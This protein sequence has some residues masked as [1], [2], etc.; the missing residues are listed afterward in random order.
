MTEF[1]ATSV[2][3]HRPEYVAQYPIW[4][5]VRDAACGEEAIK[6]KSTQYLPKLGGHTADADGAALYA[7]YLQYAHWYGATARTLAGLRGLVFR[8]DPLKSI[9]DELTPYENNITADGQSLMSFT[10]DVLM[11][12]LQTNRCGI[13]IDFPNVDIIENYS[14]ADMEHMNIRPYVRMYRAENI[15]NWRTEAVNNETVTTLVVLVENIDEPETDGFS[16]KRITQYR[17]LYLDRETGEYHQR[18]Y[19]MR[20]SIELEGA[21][22]AVGGIVMLEDVT[23]LVNGKVLTSIPFFPITDKGITWDITNSTLLPL[24]NTNISHYCNSANREQA[25]I[26]TGN[27]TPVFSGYVGNPEESSIRLGSTEAVLLLNGGTASF[28]E[29]T[30]QGIDPIKEAMLEK[31]EEMAVLGARIIAPEKRV[32][33]TAESA[34][35]HRAGEQGVL[36]DIANSLSDG[37]TRVLRFFGDFHGI[38]DH[39]KVWIKLNTDFLPAPMAPEMLKQLASLYASNLISWKTYVYQLQQGEILPLGS[40][41]DSEME[42]ITNDLKVKD[43]VVQ[44]E[45]VVE[46][47]VVENKTIKSV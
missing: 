1:D 3:W 40:T 41:S 15:I 47:P 7:L 4:T 6:A 44:T 21:T 10:K 33:E 34:A 22:G 13:F 31:E 43:A 46:K 19:Q 42:E 25:L 24:V 36:A 27:P 37:L 2:G 5:K 8:K 32:A 11:E 39:M 20:D 12:V 30:G 26:W 14:R 9:P 28:L 18:L 23:P 16:I 45:E 17:L 29:F 38:T 35:I